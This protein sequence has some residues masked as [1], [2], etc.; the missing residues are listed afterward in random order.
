MLSANASLHAYVNKL[1][2]ELRPAVV[3]EADVLEIVLSVLALAKAALDASEP[4]GRYR[5]PNAQEN[6]NELIGG[7]Q[8][9]L[10]RLE[11]DQVFIS[12]NEIEVA[13][14]LL[15]EIESTD[16][17]PEAWLGDA[18]QQWN[19]LP[20][21]VADL[22]CGL[23]EIPT[24]GSV[25]APW[26]SFGQ[27]AVRVAR[28]N[29]KV[30]VESP[31]KFGQLTIAQMLT[32]TSFEVIHS[33]PILNS[34]VRAPDLRTFDSVIAVPPMG[35]AYQYTPVF[36]RFKRF[37]ERS[38]SSTILGIQHVL[39]HA[40]RRAVVLVPSSFLSNSGADERL[41]RNLLAD[42]ILQA[43]VE[44]PQG[45]LG[46]TIQTAVLVLNPKGGEKVVRFVDATSEKF[47]YKV[48]K[49]RSQ[50]LEV[51]QLVRLA[52]GGVMP[53]DA[54]SNYRE[55][56]V[57]DVMSLNSNLQ[58][59]RHV[60][61]TAA[62]EA[63]SMLSAGEVAPLG[64]LV[65]HISSLPMA[66]I[67][68]HSGVAPVQTV[69]A[70]GTQDIQAH[71]F[72]ATIGKTIQLAEKIVDKHQHLLLQPLDVV[73]V[74]KGSVGKVGILSAEAFSDGAIFA[75]QAVIALRVKDPQVM[76]AK[77]LYAT[78]RSPLGK[79]LLGALVAGT[80]TP[81]IQLRELLQLRFPVLTPEQ[82]VHAAAM[83]DEEQT[84]QEQIDQLR[85]KQANLSAHFLA[86]EERESTC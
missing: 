15:T 42:G 14:K 56:P 83:L 17:Q 81:L 72:I 77:A 7:A 24:G 10:Q 29:A 75:G 76:D 85:T 60:L 25:Y 12:S 65:T 32:S 78:L 63:N 13:R 26:D 28:M 18:V 46:T 54:S 11:N 70:V 1:Q 31:A 3:S 22:I 61:S 79:Q 52:L 45:I 82:Q 62:T 41:R 9:R 48:S 21:E 55:I 37:L 34:Q 4:G 38:T 58:A 23:A 2:D 80:T 16:I 35:V 73:L 74:I 64:E 5:E 86:L 71:G 6:L 39:M 84:I 8:E 33:E 57:D 36:D 68:T 53:S 51:Q 20:A 50:L 69:R 30:T 59:K 19:C 49:A 27:L 67:S 44:L 47:H 40:Q 43:V 66:A